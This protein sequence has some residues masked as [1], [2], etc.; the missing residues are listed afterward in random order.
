MPGLTP[1]QRSRQQIDAQLVACGWV[2]QDYHGQENQGAGGKPEKSIHEKL[3]LFC[4]QKTWC[5][6]VGH[7]RELTRLRR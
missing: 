1:E 6:A 5:F 3:F 4:S 7:F 2:I